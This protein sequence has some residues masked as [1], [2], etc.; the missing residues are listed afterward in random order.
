MMKILVEFD[1][2][3]VNGDLQGRTGLAWTGLNRT[4]G[5]VVYQCRGIL[6]GMHMPT[7]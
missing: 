2:E 7:I 5:G 4:R 1:L 3:I 6:T